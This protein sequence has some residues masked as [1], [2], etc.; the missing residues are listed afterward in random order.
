MKGNFEICAPEA[1]HASVPSLI[2]RP[3]KRGLF[4]ILEEAM[5]RL[6]IV[7]GHLDAPS[8]PVQYHWQIPLPHRDIPFHSA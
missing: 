8:M 4:W 6:E 7:D 3:A 2:K 1:I 5:L